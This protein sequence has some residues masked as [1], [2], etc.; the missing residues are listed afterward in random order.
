[1]DHQTAINDAYDTAV[2]QNQHQRRIQSRSLVQR[3]PRL[4][5][6]RHHPYA[7]VR[8][9]GGQRC[10]VSIVFARYC[11]GNR[12]NVLS[13]R[14]FKRCISKML[15][16]LFPTFPY[17]L[18]SR[19]GQKAP[20]EGPFLFRKAEQRAVIVQ[21]AMKALKPSR[22]KITPLFFFLPKIMFHWAIRYNTYSTNKLPLYIHDANITIIN[23]NCGEI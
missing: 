16:E 13:G 9:F 6:V 22:H 14:C 8:V 12:L 5:R 2:N 23:K 10:N 1:M 4:F 3:S 18:G 21:K 11:W 20:K 7:R 15:S 17:F 19:K